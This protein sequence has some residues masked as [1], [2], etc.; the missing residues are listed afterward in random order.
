MAALVGGLRADV[1]RDAVAQ[2][3]AAFAVATV[4]EEAAMVAQAVLE[5]R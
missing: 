3:E 5:V 1:A 2:A 4:E